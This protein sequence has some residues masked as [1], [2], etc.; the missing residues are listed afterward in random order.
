[1]KFRL[2]LQQ[3]HLE[4][5]STKRMSD[6]LFIIQCRRVL[7]AMFK[8]V[9]ELEETSKDQNAFCTMLTVIE[10]ETISS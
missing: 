10:K 1:M 3:S 8:S 4:W 2:L 5:E 7:K 6:S 9:E